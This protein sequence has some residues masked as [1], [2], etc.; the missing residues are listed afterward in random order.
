MKAIL[1]DFAKEQHFSPNRAGTFIPNCTP[2]LF[3]KQMNICQPLR[4]LPGYADFC[5][6]K[7]VRNWT[8]AKAGTMPITTENV[9][10]LKSEYKARKDGELPV[11]VRWFE[12]LEVP[13]AEFLVLV[14]Y[15][16]E[17]LQKEE[18]EIGNDSWGV[19]AILGQM[20]D[21]EE[22]MTP[23]TAMRNALGVEEGGSGEPLD[24][25]A[26]LLSAEFWNNHATV[27]AN[28]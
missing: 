22:P 2:E 20:H 8:E 11:L 3:E 19:V 5:N 13:R 17:Q 14:L 6:L 25:A 23:I 27:K 28:F 16:A 18:V 10:F 12:G 15:S 21:E 7:V 1:T 26:Y 9:P 4:W 24:K